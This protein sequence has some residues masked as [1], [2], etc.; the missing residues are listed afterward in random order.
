MLTQRHKEKRVG[1]RAN[2]WEKEREPFGSPLYMFVPPLGLSYINWASL[3]C[4]LFHLRSSLQPAGLS[5]TFLCGLF[6]SLSFRHCH[7]G[8][9]F[10]ILTT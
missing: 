5:L 2:A 9:L 4:C 8:L 7:F 10:L 3:E 6:P 1:E